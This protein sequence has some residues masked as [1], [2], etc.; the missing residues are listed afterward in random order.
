MDGSASR[1]VIKE[2]NRASSFAIVLLDEDLQTKYTLVGA[3]TD[4]LP[5]TSQAA[6]NVGLAMTSQLATGQ[7]T[8][9]FRLPQCG[10][11]R[12][13]SSQQAVESEVHVCRSQEECHPEAWPYVKARRDHDTIMALDHDDR[14]LALANCNADTKAKAA[15]IDCHQQPSHQ[16]N[17]DL[18][19][20][21]DRQSRICLTFAAVLK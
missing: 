20:A 2:T 5:Q 18:A 1:F 13:C 9:F 12:Q 11:D 6:E 4:T 19:D 3:V 17:K 16:Q 8:A 10:A 21:M 15:R 14:M 7:W